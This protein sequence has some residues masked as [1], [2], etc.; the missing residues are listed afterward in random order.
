MKLVYST[1][2]E[3]HLCKLCEKIQTK[4]SRIAKAENNI[5]RWRKEGNRKASIE[6][7]EDEI[8]ALWAEIDK[9]ERDREYKKQC[10]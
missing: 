6:K 1:L 3:S 7:A 4:R 5:K 2:H 8:D 9:L 10:L